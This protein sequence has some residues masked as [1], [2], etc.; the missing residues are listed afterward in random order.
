[1]RRSIGT[2]I[3]D[4][5]SRKNSAS[6]AGRVRVERRAQHVAGAGRAHDARRHDDDEVGFFLLVGGAARERAED[7]HVGEPGQ[8]LLVRGVDALQQAGDREALAVAQLHRGVGAPH[9]QRRDGDRRR[10]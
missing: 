5:P 6:F 2:V 10:S 4:W 7:R 1:M 8:L 9:D 3:S